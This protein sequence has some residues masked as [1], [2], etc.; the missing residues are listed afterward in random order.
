ME[1]AS[2]A[3]LDPRL[4]HLRQV[5]RAFQRR[6]PLGSRG[7]FPIEEVIGG[8]L[9]RVVDRP[10]T[11]RLTHVQVLLEFEEPP[12][13]D[14]MRPP[15]GV[16]INAGGRVRTAYLPVGKLEETAALPGLRRVCPSLRLFR[17]MDRAIPALAAAGL[18]QLRVRG[19]G[20]VL[21]G[22]VDTGI[23]TSHPDFAGRIVRL[24]DQTAHGDG[25]TVADYGLEH[26]TAG[27]MRASRDDIG[28]GT[29]LAGIA[30]GAGG[31]NPK[32][33]LVVVKTGLTVA[34][35]LD[36]VRYVREVAR[37]LDLPAVVNLSL[38][39]HDGPHDGTGTF[40]RGIDEL[41]GPGLI[42][43]AA[44]GNEGHLPIHA[45]SELAQGGE[46]EVQVLLHH[47][48]GSGEPEANLFG[49]ARRLGDGHLE[50]AVEGPEI[51]GSS[52]ITPSYEPIQS[53]RRV[54]TRRLPGGIVHIA[55]FP[56]EAEQQ[57]FV[58]NI[59]PDIG[60]VHPGPW[61]IHL[62]NKGAGRCE[63]DLWSG[64][65]RWGPAA[66]LSGPVVTP[67]TTIGEPGDANGVITVGAWTSR[68]AWTSPLGAQ[69]RPGRLGEVTR[70]SSLGPRRDGRP[71]PDL[72]A[73]GEW[74]V[75]ARSETA[76]EPPD[77]AVGRDRV[78]YRGTSQASAFVSGWVSLLLAGDPSLDPEAVR[79]RL[80]EA[81]VLPEA[82][83]PSRWGAGRLGGVEPG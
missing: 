57:R 5:Y 50:I 38:G 66:W 20:Q 35:V 62:Q 55:L 25:T 76:P 4:A 59:T 45:R 28:H 22:L 41:V 9:I 72:L 37:E 52:S 68:L 70:F 3:V 61:T 44:A 48:G 14:L 79:Q 23:D 30:A 82:A 78:A 56:L 10:F 11:R 2:S 51:E 16:R 39:I 36:G 73:P 60:G 67:E 1:P 71:K 74:I 26:R 40:A 47:A 27:A 6:G 63:V 80:A 15:R 29:H 13:E 8:R 53:R 69:V 54:W 42:V 43:C 33:K 19:R 12:Q 17:R 34:E 64:E 75:S 18:D 24:W 83:E 65:H 77:R 49:W 46:L 21:I 58:I 31:V 81:T 7:V 32:A